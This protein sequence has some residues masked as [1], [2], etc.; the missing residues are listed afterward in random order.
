LERELERSELVV[1]EALGETFRMRE[2]EAAWGRRVGELEVMLGIGTGAK[3]GG[4]AAVVPGAKSD[5]EGDELR[6]KLRVVA[7]ERND[8][9]RLLAE[10]RKVMCMAGGG[11]A[12][13]VG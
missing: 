4:A 6:E 1:A 2:T 8:A 5:R 10:V 9:L 11:A 13:A 3:E 12:A 7:R